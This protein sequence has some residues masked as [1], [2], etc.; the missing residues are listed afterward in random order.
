MPTRD[1][2]ERLISHTMKEGDVVRIPCRDMNEY[3]AQRMT[4]FRLLK[5]MKSQGM[6]VGH[7]VIRKNTIDEQI[8]LEIEHQSK[9]GPTFI[10]V[11][12]DGK[13][14]EH[15]I[16]RT[17]PTR[18]DQEFDEWMESVYALRRQEKE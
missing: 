9:E 11:T 2:Y 10:L 12:K 1:D 17:L 7:M 13:E 4:V 6:D 8:F 14:E 16:D 5:T 15:K 3:H 18:E